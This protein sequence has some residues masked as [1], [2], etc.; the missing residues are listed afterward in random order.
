M[1]LGFQA[2]EQR[3]KRLDHGHNDSK[4]EEQEQKE[5]L[6]CP[7]V[8]SGPLELSCLSASFHNFLCE[9]EVACGRRANCLRSQVLWTRHPCSGG[10]EGPETQRMRGGIRIGTRPLQSRK[11]RKT[12]WSG[13]SAHAPSRRPS[14][15]PATSSPSPGAVRADPGPTASSGPRLAP[16][17]P[18]DPAPR[19]T[20][21]V[22]TP[23]HLPPHPHPPP[24]PP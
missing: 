3:L 23:P 19:L 5:H 6:N 18:Q 7:A 12:V 4:Q 21:A 15:L 1:I 20:P 11:Q 8:K 17:G 9:G 14:R 13:R 2:S 10:C 24:P 16:P 22:Q